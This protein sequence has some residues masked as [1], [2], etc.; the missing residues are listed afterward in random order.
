[1]DFP[2][3]S[4]FADKISIQLLQKISNK[5]YNV[6]EDNYFT[7]SS[8]MEYLW[9]KRTTYVG[10][11]R[12]NRKELPSVVIRTPKQPKGATHFY[13]SDKILLISYT[14]KKA[15]QPVLLGSTK[16]K[17]VT[18]ASNAKPEVILDYNRFKS[19]VDNL[20]HKLR[21]YTSKRKSRRWTVSFFF[22]M[23]D[24]ALVNA[25]ILF[26]EIVG[27]KK[28]SD[29]LEALALSLMTPSFQARQRCPNIRKETRMAL[30]I[31]GF[32]P[33]TNCQ[34]PIDEE[35]RKRKRCKF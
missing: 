23:I 9:D 5:G 22:N 20:D 10:T 29:F 8:L 13:R 19:G 17:A 16:H 31:I 25:H 14:D 34:R 12:R 21:I 30:A 24:I 28:R 6:T 15:T 35:S 11:Y 2:N 26:T 18:V 3:I 33:D 27:R 4:L 32:S 1:L 7:S